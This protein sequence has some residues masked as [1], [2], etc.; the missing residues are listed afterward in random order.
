MERAEELHADLSDVTDSRGSDPCKTAKSVQSAWNSFLAAKKDSA[1]VLD[2]PA[3]PAKMTIE[4]LSCGNLNT[5]GRVHGYD[6]D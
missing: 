6:C 5:R 1:G 2:A 3:D 4:H